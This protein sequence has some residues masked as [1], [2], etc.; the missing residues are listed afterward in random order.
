MEKSALKELITSWAEGIEFDEEQEFLQVN[1]PREHLHEVAQKLKSTPET[2][3]D[4]LFC[5]TGVD[6]PDCLE[7]VYHLESSQHGHIIVARA[8]TENR[9]NTTLDTVCDIWPTAEFHEREIYDLLGVVFNNHPDL[10]RLLLTDEWEGHP[11][12]KDYVDDINMINY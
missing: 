7:V 9:E 5:Q 12:R 4:Y 2:S 10:R 11:L 3:F 1:I 6:W 8:K